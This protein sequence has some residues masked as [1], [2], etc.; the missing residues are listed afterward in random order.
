[1]TSL[2]HLMVHI[3]S[4][5]SFC[6]VSKLLLFLLIVKW[7]YTNVQLVHHKGGGPHDKVYTPFA[8]VMSINFIS[9]YANHTH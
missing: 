7:Y 3:T 1:M 6:S 4:Q 2:E 5:Y 8:H 9:V